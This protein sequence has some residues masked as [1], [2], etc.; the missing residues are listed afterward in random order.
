M[1]IDLAEKPDARELVLDRLLDATRTAIW[2]CWT[3]PALLTR[4]FTPPPWTTEDVVVDLQPGGAFG[5]TMCGPDGE[6]H[7]NAGVY[8]EV[9]PGE[10]LVFTDAYL[11]AWE[12][13]EK[14]FFTGII[15][16]SDAPGGT[17]YLARA[18][19]WTAEDCARHA[20]MGFH[21][22]WGKCADQLEALARTR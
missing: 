14:P 6:R 18:R 9:V 11:R 7:P 17:R 22:G 3:E 20:E 10:R 15:E 5:M 2:R 1:T 12:P 4:W 16:L 13:A 19:H 8:L 21:E